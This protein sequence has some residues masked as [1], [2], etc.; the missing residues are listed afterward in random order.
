MLLLLSYDDYLCVL[1]EYRAAGRPLELV[2][3][4]ER[5]VM[6]LLDV[7]R[8]ASRL[9]TFALKF[10]A[11]EKAAE[12]TAIFKVKLIVLILAMTQ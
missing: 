3:E 10:T 11:A 6:S 9:K 4:A 1:Q 8:A 12:A 7:P 5:Y 2:S